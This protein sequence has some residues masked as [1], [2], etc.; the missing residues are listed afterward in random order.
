MFSNKGRDTIRDFR[1]GKDE[2]AFERAA[3]FADLTM[4]VTG[5]GV[6]VSYQVMQA[7]LRK[8]DIADLDQSDFIF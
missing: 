1:D 4:A 7:Y 6:T 8:T 2:I 5:S 3:G